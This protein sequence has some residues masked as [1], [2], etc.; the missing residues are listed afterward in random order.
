[1]AYL[2]IDG[3]VQYESYIASWL[4]ALRND[5]HYIFKASSAALKVHRYL[6][7]KA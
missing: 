1:M 4:K 5:R 6:I 3:E 7:D 2:E